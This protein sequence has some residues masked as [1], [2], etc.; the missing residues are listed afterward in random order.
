M[1]KEKDA[2][3]NFHLE[4]GLKCIMFLLNSETA[5]VKKIYCLAFALSATK[6]RIIFDSC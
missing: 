2:W 6:S 5:M 3:I 1:G 4:F